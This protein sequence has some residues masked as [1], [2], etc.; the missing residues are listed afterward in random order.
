[1]QTTKEDGSFFIKRQDGEN[2][3]IKLSSGIRLIFGDNDIKIRRD[4]SSQKIFTRKELLIFS[5]V[6]VIVTWAITS[7]VNYHLWG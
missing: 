5:S 6:V 1:M 4:Y 2:I 3:N 7:I